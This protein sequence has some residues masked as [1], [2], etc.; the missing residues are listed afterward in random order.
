MCAIPCFFSRLG[1]RGD[2]KL[3]VGR[4]Y[5][6]LLTHGPNGADDFTSQRQKRTAANIKI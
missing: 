5:K 4:T 3:V 6:A 1:R 2:R